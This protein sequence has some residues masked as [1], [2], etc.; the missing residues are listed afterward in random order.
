M[1]LTEFWATHDSSDFELG[2]EIQVEITPEMIERRD[3][4][5]I[6]AVICT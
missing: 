4:R 6:E 3:L 2:E 1:R 5:W